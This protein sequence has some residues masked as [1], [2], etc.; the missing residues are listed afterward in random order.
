M[1]DIKIASN[2]ELEATTNDLSSPSVRLPIANDE[3]G[4]CRVTNVDCESKS[5]TC[6]EDLCER[7]NLKV[8]KLSMKQITK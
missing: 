3:S 2:L 1:L 5:E 6:S 4:H 8:S 7:R